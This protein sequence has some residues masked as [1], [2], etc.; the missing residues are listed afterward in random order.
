MGGKV[1]H[2]GAALAATLHI[3]D[4]KTKVAMRPMPHL[5]AI[6]RL[7]S[8]K[9]DLPRRHKEHEAGRE[10]PTGFFVSFVSL[11]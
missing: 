6:S 7:P 1:C 4:A 9:E 2:C 3:V 5:T 8:A 10:A 11:W